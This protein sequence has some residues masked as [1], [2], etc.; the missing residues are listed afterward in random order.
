M[1]SAHWSRILVPT[2]LSPLGSEAVQLAHALAEKF[3]AELH[4]L[5]V[6]RNADELAKLGGVTGVL[7]P[8]S[9]Q[10]EQGRWL[11]G[12]LGETGSLR[13]VEAVRIGAD[14]SDVILKYANHQNIELI[15]MGSHGR[16]GLLHL[17]MGSIA[18]QV[19]RR[20]PC[21]V[22]VYRPTASEQK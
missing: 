19:L 14:V 15:V 12:L 13:R 17:L 20:S 18:E 3:Q 7:E 16:S 5:H 6:A 9:G 2:D 4:V 8:G 21:P 22:L 1:Q 10:D 11:A